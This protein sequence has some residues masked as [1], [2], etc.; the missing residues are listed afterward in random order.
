MHELDYAQLFHRRLI[1]M[2]PRVAT[3]LLYARFAYNIIH[4]L[5]PDLATL[6]R[7]FPIPKLVLVM[8]R[9][10]QKARENA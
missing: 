3:Q 4:L 2:H 1:Y 9:G 6:G 5:Y 8:R 10:L 7:S